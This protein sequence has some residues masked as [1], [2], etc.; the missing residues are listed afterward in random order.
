MIR[1]ALIALAIA[2]VVSIGMLSA[3]YQFWESTDKTLKRADRELRTSRDKFRSV[4]EQEDMIATFYPQFQELERQGIIG[5]ERRLDWIENL[6]RA[7]ENL[8]LPKL[9][10]TI[11]SQTPFTT[12]FPLAGGAYELFASKM[13][14]NLGLLH[15]QDLFRLLSRLDEDG[16]GLYSVDTCDLVRRQD[17]PG[18]PRQAH[19]SSKCELR[20]FTIK[21]PGE[22]GGAS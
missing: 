5:R 4:A 14:L 10:Y 13:N 1:G 12:E 21:K 6:K 2:V 7:D 3:S 19:V 18:S 15:G 9:T 8:K 17:V 22:A 11:D 20:W 16:Q